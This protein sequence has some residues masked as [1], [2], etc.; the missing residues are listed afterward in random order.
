MLFSVNLYCL[1]CERHSRAY[2]EHKVIIA[3]RYFIAEGNE[4]EA[5][6]TPR[7]WKPTKATSTSGTSS[8]SS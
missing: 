4:A 1:W 8:V 3:S 5:H 7:Q 2:Y 6:A